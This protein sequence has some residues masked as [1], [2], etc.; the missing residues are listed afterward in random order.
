M[1]GASDVGG[2]GLARSFLPEASLLTDGGTG[3]L[4]GRRGQDKEDSAVVT[5]VSSTESPTDE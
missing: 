2:L 4:G 1:K 3:N 5:F